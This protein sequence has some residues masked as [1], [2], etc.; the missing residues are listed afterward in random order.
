VAAYTY[1]HTLDD[2]SSNRNQN[3]PMDN[4]NGGLDYGAA[5]FDQRHHFSLTLNYA[6]PGR[7]GFG[8]M[9]EGW[10]INSA[11]LLQSGLPWN[12][13][14]KRDISATGDKIADRWDFLAIPAISPLVEPRFR[15]LPET[16]PRAASRY[17]TPP[18]QRVALRKLR[19]S[20]RLLLLLR[21]PPAICSPSVALCRAVRC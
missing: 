20:G 10:S 6:I 17:S 12:P 5:N 9:L 15:S 7:K 13:A 19:Q 1:S 18:S 11:V 14:D 8:Q 2:A 3:V 21:M 16:S 4:L